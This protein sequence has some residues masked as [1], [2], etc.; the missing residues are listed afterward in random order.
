MI[1]R[2]R[3][4]EIVSMIARGSSYKEALIENNLEYDNF[5]EIGGIREDVNIDEMLWT[6]W[7]KNIWENDRVVGVEFGGVKY[8]FDFE[9]RKCYE[10]GKE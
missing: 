3:Q 7:A 10:G 4:E 2:I 1:D 9:S 8:M 6:G 5:V